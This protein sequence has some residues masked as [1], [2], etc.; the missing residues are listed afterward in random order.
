MR[1]VNRKFSDIKKEKI[2][3]RMRN[4]RKSPAIAGDELSFLNILAYSGQ[5]KAP[6][7]RM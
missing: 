2:S 7:T 1:S 4:L 6:F 3:I 5:L